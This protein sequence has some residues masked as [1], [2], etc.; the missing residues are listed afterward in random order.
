MHRGH[1]SIYLYSQ[2]MQFCLGAVRLGSGEHFPRFSA[3][4][5]PCAPPAL[6]FACPACPCPACRPPCA[7][8]PCVSPA[9]RAPCSR[10]HSPALHLSPHFCSKN[11][12][13]LQL[14]SNLCS[15]TALRFHCPAFR[16]PCV[17][18]AL[19][20][21]WGAWDLVV[22]ATALRCHFPRISAAELPCV[23]TVL[24]FL[25]QNCTPLPV[26]SHFCSKTALRAHC[27]ALPLPCAST[28]LQGL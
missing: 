2:V 24:A 14:S 4:P 12:R 7:P 6:R 19:R 9:L 26:S 20:C 16:L 1:A 5:L 3:M 18:T 23:A 21:H 8:L 28:A 17:S 10:S 27:P 22:G 25:Q 11:C 13:P 15:K